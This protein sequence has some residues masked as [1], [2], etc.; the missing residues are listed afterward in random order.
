MQ[1]AEILEHSDGSARRA[2]LS[3]SLG[4]T[5]YLSLEFTWNGVE[6]LTPSERKHLV[7][8]RLGV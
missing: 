6:T 3:I 5:I 7:D 1:F 2:G 4:L 8:E